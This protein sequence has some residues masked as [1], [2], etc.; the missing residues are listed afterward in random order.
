MC[1]DLGFT[2][3]QAN[4]KHFEGLKPDIQWRFELSFGKFEKSK[5]GAILLVGSWRLS[6]FSF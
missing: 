3:G 4:L 1:E 2:S 6:G 5:K